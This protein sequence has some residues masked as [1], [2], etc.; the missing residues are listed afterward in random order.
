MAALVALSFPFISLAATARGAVQGCER[1][2]MVASLQFVEISC[3]VLGGTA[4]VLLGFGVAGAVAGFLI[5]GIAAAAL[6]LYYTIY[7]LGVRVRG[8]LELPALN[9]VAPMFGA[10]LGLSLLLNLD[11]I[12][13]KL[14]S[15]GRA[16]VGYYQAGI[17]L[18]NAPYFL[19][20]AALV[21]ILFVRLARF[22]SLAPTRKM[23][24]ETLSMIVVF[25]LPIEFVLM[26]FPHEMLGMLFPSSYAPGAPS[27]RLLAIG[28]T[29]LIFVGILSATFQAIGRARVPALTL[30]LVALVEPIVL[31][32]VVPTQ[33]A[34]GAASV[35][36][37]ASATALLCLGA[38]YLRGVG[39]SAVRQPLFWLFRYAAALGIGAAAGYAVLGAGLGNLVALVVGG[40]CY[41]GAVLTLRLVNLPL[42]N[43]RL[44]P[45]R[46][47]PQGRSRTRCVSSTWLT[48][49][50]SSRGAEGV[51]VRAREINSRLADRHQITALVAG[52][53]GARPRVENGVRWVPIGPRTGSR[54]TAGV[55]RPPRARG[56]P[57]APRPRCR[58]VRRPFQR[59]PIPPLYQQAC[60][61]LGPVALCLADA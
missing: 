9:L 21:P 43:G 3:K 17:V 41:L 33:A 26:V 52:Y 40:I 49:T 12:S 44:C 22:D 48:K 57:A 7:G 13:L 14:L 56:G 38:V 31:W 32:L 58:G 30:L 60:R 45:R 61:R 6:G 20:M 18:A 47:F 53:P 46:R 37:G 34:L 24:G 50:R 11:L 8:A 19:V 54:S 10:L 28:N 36:I 35:F 27:M 23:V 29:L 1:F 5:G 15:G 42:P 39:T 55:L 16:L 59:R 2:G 4:L 51:S 25:V